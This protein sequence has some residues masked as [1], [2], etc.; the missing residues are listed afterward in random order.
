LAKIEIKHAFRL[1]PVHP[2]DRHL[3]AMRWRDQIFVDTYLPFGLR[4]APKLFNVL[5]DL[6]SCI[7]EQ[8]GVSPPLH[9]LN[10]FFLLGPPQSPQCQE[11]LLIV[12]HMCSLLGIPLAL[13]KVEGPAVYLT[14][15]GITLD[16]SRMEARLLAEKLNRI[17]NSVKAWVWRKKLPS[18]KS[19]PW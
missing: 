4:S 10:D 8:Q 19:C 5:A 17:R 6:L 16:T 14:F 2:V 7:L 15:L 9:Y 3:L 12:R 18:T 11:N 1:L 13:E